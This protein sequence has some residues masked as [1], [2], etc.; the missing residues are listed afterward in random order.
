MAAR[1]CKA[2]ASGGPPPV[3]SQHGTQPNFQGGGAP[4]ALPAH[5]QSLQQHQGQ[6][7]RPSHLQQRT[8][9]LPSTQPNILSQTQPYQTPLAH[10]ACSIPQATS[11]QLHAGV[12]QGT[13]Q[14]GLIVLPSA[15]DH[16]WTHPVG[17]V[18]NHGGR[19]SGS[20]ICALRAL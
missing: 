15:G 17:S 14:V 19:V 2:G 11:S 12:R 6:P 5:H 16:H 1:K 7:T 13:H 3:R 18:A 4:S 9:A 20:F 10:M 8:A